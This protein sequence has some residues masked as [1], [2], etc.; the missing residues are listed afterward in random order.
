[1]Q[2]LQATKTLWL[3]VFLMMMM[4]IRIFL[5]CKPIVLSESYFIRLEKVNTLHFFKL[6]SILRRFRA[7]TYDNTAKYALGEDCLLSKKTRIIWL[8]IYL[9]QITGSSEHSCAKEEETHI[10]RI[11]SQCLVGRSEKTKSWKSKN[12]QADYLP[13]HSP[14]VRTVFEI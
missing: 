9:Q 13:R 1:M 6:W 4:M 5:D 8:K 14:D 2:H 12:G 10:G 3:A 11:K 7:W